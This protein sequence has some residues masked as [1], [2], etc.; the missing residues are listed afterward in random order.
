MTVIFVGIHNKPGMKPLDSSTLSGKAI[1]AVIHQLQGIQTV[2]AN[3]FD[4]DYY[5]DKSKREELKNEFIE[6]FELS[7]EDVYVLLGSDVKRFLAKDM[8]G[9]NVVAA[10]HPGSLRYSNY[11]RAVYA[12][13]LAQK[14]KQYLKQEASK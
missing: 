12:H 1:D 4:V 7:R 14:I 11:D 6:R 3:L 10:A 5:P 9:C 13:E 8:T 2:K